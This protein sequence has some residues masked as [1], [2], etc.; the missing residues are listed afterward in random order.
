LIRFERLTCDSDDREMF[1][2]GFKAG[3]FPDL[4]I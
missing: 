1:Q 3:F 2:P 4:Q